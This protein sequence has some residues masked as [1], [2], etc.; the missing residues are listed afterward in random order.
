M[1][2]PTPEQVFN[3]SRAVIIAPAGC[4][5][6]E[7]IARAVGLNS[8]LRQLV[9]T[10]TNAGVNSLLKRFHRLKIPSSKYKLLTIAS[11]ALE[12]ATAFPKTS[13]VLYEDRQGSMDWGK[14]YS[15]ATNVLN[16]KF[17]K[18]IIKS[19]YSGVFVDEY[20]DCT[21]LQHSL[22]TCLAEILPCRVFGDPLQGIFEFESSP[23]VDWNND[24]FNFYDQ[25]PE[26]TTPW[27][28]KGYNEKLGEWLLKIRPS[29]ESGTAIDLKSLPKNVHRFPCTPENQLKSC[30]AALKK[31]G[32]VVAIHKWKD[33]AHNLARQLG[34]K[35]ASIEEIEGN[36]LIEACEKI[37]ISN[38]KE[39][40]IAMIDFCSK[41][42]TSISTELSTIKSKLDS[43]SLELKRLSKHVNIANYLFDV[44]KWDSLKDWSL[45]MNMIEDIPTAKLFRPELWYDMKNASKRLGDVKNTESLS[46]IA[47]KLRQL[48]SILGRQLWKNTVSR[49]LLIKG[50][51]YDNS[52]ILN[53]DS[54]TRK[55]LY[56]ALTR[57]RNTMV[58]LSANSKI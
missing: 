9:L 30:F 22:I 31:S 48:H 39:R 4:G 10:H 3:H 57:A 2:D 46:Q 32:T 11:F 34:G 12:Y 14:V 16:S 53:A 51:E 52:I 20:Q 7:L 23:L 15:G 17:G 37:E 21:I 1:A 18:D 29:I 27:R 44:V 36:D 19:S 13:G 58:I 47:I 40:A 26:L 49:V 42:F 45:L 6:T 5:K 43:N 55:E 56:V 35:Y 28:W 50:L 38:G 24:V 8:S 25:L 54:L 41:C 33:Q